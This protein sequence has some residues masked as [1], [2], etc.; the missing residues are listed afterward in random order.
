MN[1]SAIILCAGSGTRTGLKYNK[2]FYEI[3]NQ[4]VYEKTLSV[5]L[6]DEECQEIIV[7]C[8]KREEDDFKK[9]SHD[10]RIK[11]V[12]GGKER[13]DSVYNGLKEVTLDYVMIHDGARCFI[14]QAILDRIK[15][16][17]N[18]HDATVVMVP[19]IDTVKRVIDGKVVE[20]LVRSE[21]YN[22]QTPQS[23]KTPLIKEAYQY[24]YDHS[25]SMTDDASAVENYGKDVYVVM[26]DYNNKKI[27]TKEDLK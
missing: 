20:T 10:S 1:Y 9:L 8:K 4:T 5:F 6:N 16:A 17:L 23:F 2:M 3:E 12:E 25:I 22:A 14:T 27:T 24:A 26:G 19:S 15:E 13:Q 18:V 11:F 21:L 7:V